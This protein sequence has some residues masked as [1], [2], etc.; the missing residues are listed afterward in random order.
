[1]K[2]NLT[3]A[4]ALFLPLAALAQSPVYRN[5]FTT[6]PGP[7]LISSDLTLTIS[8]NPV[9]GSWDLK[10]PSSLLGLFIANQNG[11][12]TNATLFGTPT[13]TLVG[14]NRMVIGTEQLVFDKNFTV[15]ARI[16]NLSTAGA[17]RDFIT[18][19]NGIICSNAFNLQSTNGTFGFYDD[20]NSSNFFINQ[21]TVANGRTLN[22]SGWTNVVF[23]VP[24]ITF[25]GL[26]ATLTANGPFLSVSPSASN[27]PAA[28]EFPTANWVRT[29]IGGNGISAWN[30]TNTTLFTNTD[31][32]SLV[33]SFTT[34]SA[35]FPA[36]VT[37]VGVT[38]NQYIG[39]TSST[40]RF[41]ALSGPIVS[42]TYLFYPS[43]AGRALSLHE[44][45]Y[46]GYDGTNWTEISTTADQIIA[47]G[48]TNLVQFNLS[49][50]TQFATNAAG[51]YVE[52]RRKVGSQNSNPDVTLWVGTNT[53]SRV[54]F[55]GPS[56]ISGNVFLAVNQT[57]TGLNTFTQPIV[58]SGASLTNLVDAYAFT[59]NAIWNM[60]TTND[61]AAGASNVIVNMD[62]PALNLDPLTNNIVLTNFIGLVAG[63]SKNKVIRIVPNATRTITYPAAGSVPGAGL[64]WA[65]NAPP[66][67]NIPYTSVT[68]GSIYILSLTSF[69]TN[70]HATMTEWK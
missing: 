6:N 23:N 49:F 40:N 17:W 31:S 63:T 33:Y 13:N 29:L 65:T 38:N 12:G 64:Y 60:R 52:K 66:Q 43:G 39:A 46:I 36:R 28:N 54:D 3:L 59:S 70:L 55:S 7:A 25:T 15:G 8:S 35:P 10:V 67:G 58:G 19:L 69:G 68:N 14:T 44:E 34:N 9:T 51:F 20:K 32:S 22:F 2:K 26:V 5:I 56:S 30:T 1:M 61:F 11:L 37:Y 21:G 27:S 16:G 62:S 57:F 47:A 48:S 18:F 53:A 50:A 4:L 45:I 41:T 24:V 42:S